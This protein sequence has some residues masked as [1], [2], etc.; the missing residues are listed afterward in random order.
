[1]IITGSKRFTSVEKVAQ[2]NNS[3]MRL[4]NLCAFID[5]KE[6]SECRMIA[7]DPKLCARRNS[8]SAIRIEVANNQIVIP[9][10]H[11]YNKI[12]GQIG[13]TNVK[14]LYT[15]NAQRAG[16]VLREVYGYQRVNHYRPC[17]C[18][19]RTRCS[20]CVAS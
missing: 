10:V 6:F 13:Y 1:M 19:T 8:I 14:H 11:V 15:R 17:Y 12:F 5:K 18:S 3:I 7:S 9:S 4:Q 16:G 20:N 2:Q